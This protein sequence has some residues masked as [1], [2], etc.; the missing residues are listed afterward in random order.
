M[1]IEQRRAPMPW[2]TRPGW[3]MRLMWAAGA[4]GILCAAAGAQSLFDSGPVGF[5][6]PQATRGAVAYRESCAACHGPNLN[7]GQ[8]ASALKGA[9]F[10]AHWH[11]Q[12][13]DAL[14]SLIM[15][16]MPPA[17]PGTL[18]SRT[19]ADI[20][21]Y[22]LQENGERAGTTELAASSAPISGAPAESLAA[23]E[24]DSSPR[25]G[26]ALVDNQ[27]E[28]FRAAIAAR[29]ILLSKVTPASD[30]MLRDPAA[31]DWL[32][33]RGSYATL[34]YSRLDQINTKTVRNL[35][36]AWTL[37]LPP[38]ANEAAPLIHDGVLFIEG[39]DTVEAIDAAEGS[40]LWQYV[41]SLPD[42]LHNGRDARMR[43]MAI[44]EDKLYAPTADGHIVA[45]DVKT[46]NLRWDHAVVSPEQGVHPGQFDGAYFHISGGP[47][48]V[49]GRVIVGVSLGI[50]TGGGDFIVGLDAHSGDE[51]W[52]F[53]TI[54]RPGQPG[55]DSWNGA[56]V[57]ERY[58]SGVWS[59]G[60]Y[61]PDLNLVY[62]GTGN[63]YDVG[64]L[65]MPRAGKPLSNN[66]ALYTDSTVALDA[67]TGK[68]SWF[69]QHMNRDVWDLDWAFEQSLITLPVNGKPTKLLVTGGKSAIFD[70]VNRS[71]GKYEF[72]KDLGLQNLV[73]SIDPKSGKKNIKPALEPPAGRTDLICPGA[74]GARNWPATA[75]DPTSNTLY[76]PLLDNNCM[77]YGWNE[78]DAA[79]IAA[80]GLDVRL[81]A[82]P[83]PGNDG[84]FGR[85]EAIDLKTK[86]VVW[87]K[88]Q[89]API[90]SSLLASA[91]GLVFSGAR[92][93]RFRAYDAA[94][95]ALLWQSVLNA[96]PSSS[97]AT[98]AVDGVQYVVV[99][100]G[101]GGAFDAGSRSLTPEIIDP[102]AG[103]TVWVFKLIDPNGAAKPR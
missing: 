4:A 49:H 8:F 41:R 31:G 1:Q 101:G 17:S 59:I 36:V 30:A 90:A 85:I 70:A 88:R 51:K 58:G 16:R 91:G 79:K 45:L 2:I 99:I 26:A 80:G 46:G 33:W 52:R 98:Y 89:R 72:S 38:S 44:Y 75:I 39:A 54:A 69:Y 3:R 10:K 37:A 5:T 55:G 66:D 64:T 73:A 63:T 43:G 57:N 100:A 92:D 76:V 22:M 96:S 61:D 50:D 28:R 77:D 68:L 83:K 23:S 65:L 7:D 9:A 102:A 71:D 24:H 13:P 34:G 47:L 20:E 94:T 29:Q 62:F 12:S 32:M 42:A 84:N 86:Q 87:S 18:S 93:R 82:R 53:N 95:G 103:T 15:K 56:P 40:I 67:D 60:S 11:D 97:P 48:L 81:G 27:D 25:V 74:T 14:W 19:Y 21:A 35:G 6:E 78:R